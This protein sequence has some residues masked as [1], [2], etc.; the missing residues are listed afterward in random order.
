MSPGTM[1]TLYSN[2]STCL[3]RPPI[4]SPKT[5]MNSA[6]DSTGAAIVCVQS[7]V[8]R[9]TSRPDRAIR[10]RWRSAK[11]DTAA[12]LAGP[13]ACGGRGDRP[14]RVRG[15]LS[16]H[17]RSRAGRGAGGRHDDEAD[18]DHVA[19]REVLPEQEEPGHRRDGRFE[20]HQ[21]AEDAL[22]QR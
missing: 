19:R 20:R 11:L 4:D 8:T 3:M 5:R 16:R 22:G 13:A 7:L 15:D 14:P 10:P 18:G 21:H 1:K 6:L 2:P 17:D 12:T 9:A